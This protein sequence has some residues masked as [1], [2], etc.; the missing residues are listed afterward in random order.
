MSREQRRAALAA[1]KSKVRRLGRRANRVEK[2]VARLAAER[3]A[4]RAELERLEEEHHA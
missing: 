1:S 2:E 3:D 4:A